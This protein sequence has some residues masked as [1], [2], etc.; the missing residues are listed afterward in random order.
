MDGGAGTVLVDARSEIEAVELVDENEE[1]AAIG[2]DAAD[3]VQAVR[4]EHR[5][6]A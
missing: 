4:C 5:I 1:I 6:L 3:A 2:T